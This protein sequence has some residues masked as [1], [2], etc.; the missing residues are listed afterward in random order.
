M[1]KELSEINGRFQSGKHNQAINEIQTLL[2]TFA[3]DD[4]IYRAHAR[5]GQYVNFMGKHDEAVQAWAKALSLL[6]ND[7]GNVEHLTEEKFVDWINISLEKARVMHRQGKKKK[8]H[9][10]DLLPSE[11]SGRDGSG[12]SHKYNSDHYSVSNMND[13]E[14]IDWKNQRFQSAIKHYQRVLEKLPQDNLDL[15]RRVRTEL[16]LVL[17]D[18]QHFDEAATAYEDVFNVN[19]SEKKTKPIDVVLEYWRC[20]LALQ[21]CT[22]FMGTRKE[23][24]SLCKT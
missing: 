13:N 21:S 14:E 1:E 12:V 4:A 3:I 15:K 22:M 5:L 9:S 2:E 17:F 7:Q 23:R 11:S 18:S 16:A 8:T 24:S 6:E 19:P 20:Q 10:I